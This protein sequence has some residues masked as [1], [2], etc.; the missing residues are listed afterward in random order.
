LVGGASDLLL[1][2]GKPAAQSGRERVLARISVAIDRLNLADPELAACQIE[3]LTAQRPTR[4][5]RV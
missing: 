2:E 5:Q 4:R 3:C 1:T